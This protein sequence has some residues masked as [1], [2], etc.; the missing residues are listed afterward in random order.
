MGRK[1]VDFVTCRDA[2]W[3]RKS[4]AGGGINIISCSTIY[5]PAKNSSLSIALD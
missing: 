3:G 2:L 4:K 5:T 1:I